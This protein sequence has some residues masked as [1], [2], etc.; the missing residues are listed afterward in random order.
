MASKASYIRLDLGWI[1]LMV[2]FGGVFDNLK[3]AVK[4]Y[5]QTGHF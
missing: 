1:K 5:Y 2:H 3:L 4:H